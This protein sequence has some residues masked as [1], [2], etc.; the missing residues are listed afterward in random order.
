VGRGRG[1]VR[2]V[3]LILAFL[4]QGAPIFSSR[5]QQCLRSEAVVFSAASAFVRAIPRGI[6]SSLNSS[7]T[8]AATARIRLHDA[9][10]I[11]R[12]IWAQTSGSKFSSAILCGAEYAGR[13][14]HCGILIPG[15]ATLLVRF[16]AHAI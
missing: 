16:K 3:Q 2:I 12:S 15:T 1:R 8:A 11:A 4:V 13:E 14:T 9:N 10:Y 5:V 7:A 6:L